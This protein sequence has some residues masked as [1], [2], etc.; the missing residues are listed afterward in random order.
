MGLG[1]G[2][3][4]PLA[5]AEQAAAQG[6]GRGRGGAPAAAPAAPAPLPSLA[7]LR[8]RSTEQVVKTLRGSGMIIDG[9]V[10]P[11]DL[12]ITFANNKQNA[13]DVI[14]GSNKDEHTSLGGDPA[15]RDT[16]AWAMRLFAERQTARGKR[17]Y[18][19]YFTHE[20]PVEPG[21]KDLKATHAAEIVYA[22]NNLGA[23]RV[24]PDLSSPKL[25]LASERDRAMAETMSSYWVNFARTGDPNGRGLPEWPRF[26]DRG[27]PPHILG[28]IKEPLPVATLN[29][30]DTKYAELLNTLRAP[31]TN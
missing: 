20:P 12:S 14:V 18:W 16:M 21:V 17:A 1:M 7:E 4:T 15:F 13:V 2:A 3:M 9:W 22:F 28:E 27:A 30:Y 11:E 6:A 29:A 24:I 8:A 23:P 25:A 5:R 26:E 19:Y 31:Q 10:V